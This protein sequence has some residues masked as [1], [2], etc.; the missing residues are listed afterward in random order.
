MTDIAE[1]IA[2]HKTVDALIQLLRE[3]LTISMNY[4]IAS[5]HGALSSIIDV[6]EQGSAKVADVSPEELMDVGEGIAACHS[7]GITVNESRSSDF[8]GSECGPARV[9]IIL[10][11]MLKNAGLLLMRAIS[12]E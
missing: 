2:T 8:S 6:D 11:R 10:M 7:K 3:R 1:D 5:F 9:D 4:E 12:E